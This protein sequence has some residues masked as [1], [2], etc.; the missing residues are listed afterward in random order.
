MKVRV[1]SHEALQ[2]DSFMKRSGWNERKGGNWA[3]SLRGK[4]TEW[5]LD[6]GEKV[7]SCTGLRRAKAKHF[8][9]PSPLRLAPPT[10]KGVIG[11]SG[12]PPWT[13]LDLLAQW[14]L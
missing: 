9:K 3:S 8:G 4:E 2:G 10:E 13:I 12:A 1:L 14:E 11:G 7:G 6:P 5:L